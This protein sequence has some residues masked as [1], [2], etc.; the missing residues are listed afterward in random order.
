MCTSHVTFYKKKNVCILIVVFRLLLC[1]LTVCI[2]TKDSANNKLPA[3][4][5]LMVAFTSTVRPGM[6]DFAG[7][8]KWDAWNAKKG[9]NGENLFF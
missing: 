4:K 6:L 3:A 8:A 1:G 2:R 7:R 5:S 9:Q